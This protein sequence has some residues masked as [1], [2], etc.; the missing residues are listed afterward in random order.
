M[1]SLSLVA[2]GAL[3]IRSPRE[4][5]N[6]LRTNWDSS[7]CFLPQGFRASPRHIRRRA[8]AAAAARLEEA[9]PVVEVHHQSEQESSVRKRRIKKNSRVQPEFYHSVQGA[10]TR[11]TVSR[12]LSF[13]T[14]LNT[15]SY[16]VVILLVLKNDRINFK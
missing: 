12:E 14:I 3:C 13:L 15:L 6:K 11:R 16:G 9:K 4:F 1:I 10:P 2:L 5:P 8:A 7:G